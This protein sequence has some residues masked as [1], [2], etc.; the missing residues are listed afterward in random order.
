MR[1]TTRTPTEN[2]PS[3]PMSR[4]PAH[5]AK[6]SAPSAVPIANP[7][8]G[9]TV[10]AM[11]GIPSELTVFTNAAHTVKRKEGGQRVTNCKETR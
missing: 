8:S 3:I 7:P 4:I 2:P 11:S 1:R 10:K 5:R 9:I 6:L